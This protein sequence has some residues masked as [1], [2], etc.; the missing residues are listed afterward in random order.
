MLELRY[1]GSQSSRI[2]VVSRTLQKVFHRDRWCSGRLVKHTL[3]STGEK[4][5]CTTAEEASKR[6]Y[7][8]S[9]SDRDTDRTTTMSLVIVEARV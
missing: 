1:V 5:N 9:V 7:Q 3:L 6:I 2:E 8:V 4:L